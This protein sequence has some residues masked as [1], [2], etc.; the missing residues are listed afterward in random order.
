MTDDRSGYYDHGPRCVLG[1]PVVILGFP[2]SGARR[3]VR[4]MA[5]LTG[6][7][8]ND[9]E[10]LAE[11][12][13]GRS[14]W[15]TTQCDGFEAV[16]SSEEEALWQSL[17]RR[18]AGLIAAPASLFSNERVCR[19]VSACAGVVFLERP[20]QVLFQQLLLEFE[21]RPQ[22]EIEWAKQVPSGFEE[23]GSLLQG[24]LHPDFSPDSIEDCGREPAMRIAESLISELD[25]FAAVEGVA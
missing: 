23:L 10:R 17:R 4:S 1:R 19:R 18:P 11:G 24:L 7:P 12:K 5:G 14:R 16:R 22:A 9:V 21:L 13:R 2:G 3:V 15:Q 8:F 25:R 20:V 6:L